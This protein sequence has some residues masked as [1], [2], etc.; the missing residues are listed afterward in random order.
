MKKRSIWSKMVKMLI[1]LLVILLMLAGCGARKTVTCDGCGKQLQIKANSNMDDS[2]IIYC[3]ACNKEF[4]GE[5]GLV[6]KQ[7]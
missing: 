4:F 5:D 1:S 6:P 3:D 7:P 2:W